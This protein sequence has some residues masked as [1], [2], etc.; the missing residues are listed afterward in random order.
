MGDPDVGGLGGGSAGGPNDEE[1]YLAP[2]GFHY[3]S[4]FDVAYDE[5]PKDDRNRWHLQGYFETYPDTDPDDDGVQEYSYDGDYV[6]YKIENGVDDYETDFENWTPNESMMDDGG[7][8]DSGP[9]D[10]V[11]AFS[12][13]LVAAGAFVEMALSGD[14]GDVTWQD[15]RYV[16]WHVPL[17]SGS[18]LPTNQDDSA[19]V[20]V[21]VYN[22]ASASDDYEPVDGS[23]EY[24]YYRYDGYGYDHFVTNTATDTVSYD[25]I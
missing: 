5:I 25:P 6:N 22:Y 12:P 9:F 7:T 13:Y 16:D 3:V 23:S 2:H 18:G 20:F 17:K 10:V 1:Y 14:K 19:G 4:G 21:D 8:W 15:Y 24:A 11:S